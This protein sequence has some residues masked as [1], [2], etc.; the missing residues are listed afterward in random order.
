MSKKEDGELKVIY[1]S[2]TGCISVVDNRIVGIDWD[3][4][5]IPP[6]WKELERIVF[7]NSFMIGEM[8][9][10]EELDFYDIK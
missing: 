8:C 10:D 9:E 7:N 5:N 1:E 6:D 3:G 2:Y 4:E